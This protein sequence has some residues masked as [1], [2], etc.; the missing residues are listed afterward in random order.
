M[1]LDNNLKNKIE[2]LL[3]GYKQDVLKDASFKI[4]EK[5]QKEDKEHPVIDNELKAK[6]Y[7]ATR[8]PATY[9]AVSNA[10]EHIFALY[11][12]DINNALDIGAG[13]GAAS[14]ALYDLMKV[15][16]IDLYEKEEAMRSLGKL[17]N[18]DKP[19]SYQEFDLVTDDINNKYD[20]VMSSY[21]LNELSEETRKVAIQKMYQATKDLIIIVDPGTPNGYKII[22]EIRSAL[23]AKGMHIIAPCPHEG[24]CPM[25]QDD[26]CHFV[27]RIARSKLHKTLKEADAP[28]EDEK[29]SY[30]ALSKNEINRCSNRILRHPHIYK[31]MV[32]LI[33]CNNEGITKVEIR[34]SHP[35]YKMAKKIKV[36]D[37][38]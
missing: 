6:I 3:D 8:M 37:S 32:Q 19:F 15:D 13:L 26:W 33:S 17:L 14:L 7:A 25:S 31:G 23:L 16:H 28:Y 38:F 11:Y 22:Q 24:K 1:E 9:G 2:H 5:Y 18:E 21:V 10:L 35:N 30:I 36:G 34:K 12:K 27:A 20:L 4:I 29:F